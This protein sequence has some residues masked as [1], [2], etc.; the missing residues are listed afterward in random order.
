MKNTV[1]HSLP[2]YLKNN[3]LSTLSCQICKQ[4]KK[5][6]TNHVDKWLNE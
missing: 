5:I 6:K 3:L 4:L 2:T 1:Y